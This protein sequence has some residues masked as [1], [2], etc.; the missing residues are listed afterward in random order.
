[1]LVERGFP[2]W[3]WYQAA[4][5]RLTLG[6]VQFTSLKRYWLALL[7]RGTLLLVRDE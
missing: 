6:K 4:R 7:L 2:A 3:G 5:G 1:M